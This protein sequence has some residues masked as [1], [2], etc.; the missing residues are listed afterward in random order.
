MFTG[1]MKNRAWFYLLIFMSDFQYFS[2]KGG[3]WGEK[4]LKIY[5]TIANS[6]DGKVH[7]LKWLVHDIVA[8]KKSIEPFDVKTSFVRGIILN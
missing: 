1:D 4:I 8:P 7:L 6:N 3:D 2:A 5:R